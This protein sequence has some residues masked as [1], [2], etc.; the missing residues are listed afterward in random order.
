MDHS[1]IPVFKRPTK[2][3]T[4]EELALIFNNKQQKTSSNSTPRILEF[5]TNN[6]NDNQQQGS[7]S[8]DEYP[9]NESVLN[10]VP[11]NIIPIVH[12]PNLVSDFFTDLTTDLS[13]PRLSY[14][15]NGI[16]RKFLL[17]FHLQFLLQ[18]QSN[19]NL[20]LLQ[21]KNINSNNSNKTN[22]K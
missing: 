21:P 22:K 13:D 5:T 15:I 11:K 10:S 9:L 4:R 12:E 8:I 7:N 14:Q 1:N 17:L 6:N 18:L 20:N 16:L 19:V 3:P 2:L